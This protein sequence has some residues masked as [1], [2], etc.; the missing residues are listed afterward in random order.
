MAH[1][2]SYSVVVGVVCIRVVT[3]KCFLCSD[4]GHMDG[5]VLV[6]VWTNSGS[7]DSVDMVHGRNDG[8]EVGRSTREDLCGIFEELH[9]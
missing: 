2:H 6:G 5:Q 8:G 9:E 4:N 1:T 3:I 7:E